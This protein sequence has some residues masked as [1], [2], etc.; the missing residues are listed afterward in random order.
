[1]DASPQPVAGST[2]SPAIA[3]RL[4]N[5]LVGW[6]TSVN[7]DGQPQNS[8]V[9][10]IRDG[11]DIVMYSRP[12]ATRLTNLATNPRVAFN[13]GGDRQGDSITTLEGTAVADPDL[14]SRLGTAGYIAKYGDENVRLGWTHQDYDGLF[15]VPIRITI[16]RIRAW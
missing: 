12:D 14:P 9:W 1:M 6:L 4:D 13:L 5:E 7:A 8:A 10:Y 3:E 16:T 15:S 11:N 2:F